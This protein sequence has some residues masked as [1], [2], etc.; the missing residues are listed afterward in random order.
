MWKKY[1]AKNEPVSLEVNLPVSKSPF[2]N[3]LF[4]LELY[5]W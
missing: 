1:R 4:I 3:V 2:F 5:T